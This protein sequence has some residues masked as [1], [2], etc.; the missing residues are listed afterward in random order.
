MTQG[1]IKISGQYNENNI[2]V[3]WNKTNNINGGDINKSSY[4]GNNIIVIIIKTKIAIIIKK[5]IND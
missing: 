4:N 3:E 2:K 1:L 5:P